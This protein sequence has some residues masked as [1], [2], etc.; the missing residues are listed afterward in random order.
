VNKGHETMFLDP[1]ESYL[2]MME[3]EIFYGNGKNRQS[4]ESLLDLS[5]Q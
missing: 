1:M 2:S 5:K 4:N 3:L